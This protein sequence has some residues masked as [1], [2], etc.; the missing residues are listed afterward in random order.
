MKAFTQVHLGKSFFF[1][2]LDDL[3]L[4]AQ[5]QIRSLLTLRGHHAIRERGS[6]IYYTMYYNIYSKHDSHDRGCHLRMCNYMY[7]NYY[8]IAHFHAM[9]IGEVLHYGYYIN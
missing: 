6:I 2:E 5:G 8:L 3:N 9:T 1:H 4:L 7:F